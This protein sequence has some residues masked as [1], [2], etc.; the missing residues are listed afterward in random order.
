[1]GFADQKYYTR[2]PEE[3]LVNGTAG[4]ATASSVTGANVPFGNASA[5]GFTFTVERKL[6]INKAKV[7]IITTPSANVTGL[8]LNLV[9]YSGAGTGT[10]VG[11]AS[12][13]FAVATIGAG[14]VGQVIDFTG[15]GT[16]V[17]GTNIGGTAIT[18]IVPVTST[19]L[20]EVYSTATLPNG[21][22]VTYM[23]GTNTNAVVAKDQ[24]LTITVTGTA[25]ASGATQALGVY[26]ISYE[27]RE[28]FDSQIQP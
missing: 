11:T 6:A 23:L 27:G 25:T 18:K 9:S 17:V 16:V 4:T 8:V 20:F 28:L 22:T 3:L 2:T 19:N 13:T 24:S 7:T 15:T 21:Q 10:N 1:M 12:S 26:N 5:A 14:T